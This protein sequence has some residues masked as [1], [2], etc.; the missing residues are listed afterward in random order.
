MHR[1]SLNDPFPRLAGETVKHG[2]LTLPDDVPAGRWA[3][4]LAYRAQW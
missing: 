3:V 2:R 4:I 1:F